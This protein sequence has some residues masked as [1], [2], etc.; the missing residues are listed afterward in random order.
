MPT[1]EWERRYEEIREKLA[2][3]TDLEAYFTE[4]AIGDQGVDVLDI[5]AVHFP[6]G[7]I[8]AC[9][10]LVEL[11]DARPFLQI[12]PRWNLSRLKICAV[13]SEQYGDGYACVKVAVRAGKPVRYDLGMVGN[14]NLDEEPREGEFFG[15]GV[16]AGMG[17]SRTSRPRRPSGSTGPS[18]MEED[19]DIDPYNDLFCGLLEENFRQN[20]KYQREGGD[21]PNWTVPG[22]WTARPSP[23]RL[24]SGATGATPSTP[25]MTRRT[26]SAPCTCSSSTWKPATRSRRKEAVSAVRH[27]HREGGRRQH[28]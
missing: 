7:T 14:E 24:R 23:R 4:K 12:D 1:A 10:P 22:N 8:F 21:W 5:G 28:E 13:P 27:F 25:A 26:T 6:T 2:C 20:P 9:D 17:A 11:E 19:P 18:V 3:R 15:F 16:D